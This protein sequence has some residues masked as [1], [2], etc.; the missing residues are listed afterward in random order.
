MYQI[1]VECAPFELAE[2]VEESQLLEISEELQREFLAKQKGFI[3][4]ELLKAGDRKYV[5]LVWWK[6]KQDAEEVMETVMKS[7]VCLRYF[8]CMVT[9]EDPAAAMSY[10]SLVKT[11]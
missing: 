7:P 2:G 11:Y 8:Q 1:T 6:S 4:R 9:V 3:R 10:Y 5:D